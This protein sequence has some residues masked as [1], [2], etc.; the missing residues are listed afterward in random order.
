MLSVFKSLRNAIA[1]ALV[2]GV[3]ATSIAAEVTVFAAASLSDSLTQIGARYR[4]QSGDKIVFNFAASSTLARQIEQ[5]AP[6][7]IFF[8]AD[9]A[10][11]NGL[12][13]NGLIDPGTRTSRLGNALVVVVPDF[14]SRKITSGNDLTNRG[15]QR[16][17]LAEPTVVP[18]GVYA[19]AWLEKIRLWSVVG[20]K[21]IP[22]ENVRAALAAV[23]SGNVDAGIVYQTDAAIS[24]KAKVAYAV[25]ENES[26]DISYPMA[27][28][29][30]ARQPEAAKRFLN[31]LNSKEA[32]EVFKKF[33]FTVRD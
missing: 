11:M 25:P 1:L 9:K 24:K 16:I 3:A 2:L 22:T 28:V 10:R 12:Q 4:Q 20:P 6:A 13:T 32:A 8:S 7:D 31:Y 14:S 23:E 21:V 33:G 30:Q 18:A 26:P 17:A 5:G 29:K 19:K 15:I 27:L